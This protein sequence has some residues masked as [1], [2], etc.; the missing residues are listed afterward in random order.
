MIG[1]IQ[2]I[3][4]RDRQVLDVV[5]KPGQVASINRLLVTSIST[6]NTHLQF[7]TDLQSTLFGCPI[8]IGEDVVDEVMKRYGDIATLYFHHRMVD[9]F[10]Y[11]TGIRR[12][13]FTSD[14]GQTAGPSFRCRIGRVIFF[15][16]LTEE[17]FQ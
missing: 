13:L 16:P 17:T 1:T 10:T 15:P 8:E 7:T 2:G 5:F 3:A 6:H 11:Q 14:R 4:L 9:G 12:N